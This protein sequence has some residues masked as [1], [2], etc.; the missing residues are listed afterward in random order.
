MPRKGLYPDE[1]IAVGQAVSTP[2]GHYFHA[3]DAKGAKSLNRHGFFDES[4]CPPKIFGRMGT[5]II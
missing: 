4:L 2:K 1:M 5:G 3:K